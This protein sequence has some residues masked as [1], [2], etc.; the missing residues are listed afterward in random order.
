MQHHPYI[1]PAL[2]HPM[3]PFPHAFRAVYKK[4]L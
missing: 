4:L 2:P 3:F 1:N